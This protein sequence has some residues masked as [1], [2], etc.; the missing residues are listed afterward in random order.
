[1]GK[2]AA[3]QIEVAYLLC[4]KPGGLAGDACGDKAPEWG[5]A[6]RCRKFYAEAVGIVDERT[7]PFPVR[8]TQFLHKF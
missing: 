4:A 2:T 6:A 5:K 1:M 3:Q 7:Q 8:C